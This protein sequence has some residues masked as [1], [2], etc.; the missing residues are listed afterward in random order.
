[1]VVN[2]RRNV[3]VCDFSWDVGDSLRCIISRFY[4]FDLGVG[5]CFS[6][7][8]SMFLVYWWRWVTP[9]TFHAKLTRLW[10][11]CDAWGR[12]KEEG[13]S[14]PLGSC[15]FV[16]LMGCFYYC[17]LFDL[18]VCVR[19]FVQVWLYKVGILMKYNGSGDH[20]GWTV[21]ESEGRWMVMWRWGGRWWGMTI[22]Y[23]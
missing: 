11:S 9:L 18:L 21:R 12:G 8:V 14:S 22:S 15:V 6:N 23:L 5:L 19:Y 20:Y 3:H 13:P 10:V 7:L 16:G 1:M 4:D 2:C 17:L